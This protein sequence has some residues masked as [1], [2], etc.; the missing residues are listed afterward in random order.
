MASDKQILEALAEL[1]DQKTDGR[2]LINA[3]TPINQP[4][5]KM[6]FTIW[7]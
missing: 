2:E 1:T 3:K 7:V 4:V 5:D 6:G